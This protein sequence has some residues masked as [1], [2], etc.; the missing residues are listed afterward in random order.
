MTIFKSFDFSNYEPSSMA[1][2]YII[3]TTINLS[4]IFNMLPLYP[5]TF[6]KDCSDQIYIERDSC[7]F[8]G[9]QRRV[10]FIEDRTFM[11]NAIILR[12]LDLNL[13]KQL[14]LKIN[15]DKIHI[16]GTKSFETAKKYAN[17]LID[18]IQ[19]TTEYLKS[20]QEIKTEIME[21]INKCDSFKEFE[22]KIDLAPEHSKNWILNQLEDYKLEVFGPNYSKNISIFKRQLLIQLDLTDLPERFEIK[23]ERTNMLKYN[24]HLRNNG[25]LDCMFFDKIELIEKLVDYC[26]IVKKYIIEYDNRSLSKKITL[27]F[28]KSI[29]DKT[30]TI[31]I[32]PERKSISHYGHD[33]N[34]MEEGYEFIMK[35]FSE[36]TW[37][38][39]EDIEKIDLE[40]LYKIYDIDKLSKN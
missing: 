32:F 31:K 28:N 11:K 13:D 24:Y 5:Y 15:I 36:L 7:R 8:N 35:L 17:K 29:E 26:E 37:Y 9:F 20:L 39:L 16:C 19:E 27:M 33:I 25:I 30:H 40:K 21:F 1:K 34:E 4:M 2:M 10:C 6:S 3:N 38:R 14:S 23:E 18:I 12:L 22:Q